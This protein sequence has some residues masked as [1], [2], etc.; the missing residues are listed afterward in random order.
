M[1]APPDA[2]PAGGSDRLAFNASL[3]RAFTAAI[4]ATGVL[5]QDLRIAGR[6]LRLRFAGRALVEPMTRALRH[7][8]TAPADAPDLT[9]GVWDGDTSG[10]ALPPCPWPLPDFFVRCDAITHDWG[11]RVH[12]AFAIQSGLMQYFD[13]DARLAI[14]WARDAARL[15]AWTRAAPLR[16]LIAGWAESIGASAAHAAAVGI[17][18]RGVLLPAPSGSG[19]S[20]TA[21]ACL[22][23]GFQ[24]AGDDLVLLR[25]GDEGPTAHTVYGSAKIAPGQLASGGPG[26]RAPPDPDALISENKRVLWLDELYPR[27]LADHLALRAIVVPR[28]S[29]RGQTA[30]R[31]TSRAEVVRAL[32]PPTL[33]MLPGVGR[34]SYERLV[35]VTGALPA[36]ALELGPDHDRNVAALRGLIT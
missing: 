24:L 23:R 6:T 32:V 31:P 13:E 3:G 9:I 4:A 7:L 36:F 34:R 12:A 8:A 30:L 14:A 15:Q 18:G 26:V 20:T 27:Q 21:L 28:L 29:A 16:A 19:K 2:A 11:E 10:V 33:F 25:D 17:D 1:S 22:A 35:A 5:D